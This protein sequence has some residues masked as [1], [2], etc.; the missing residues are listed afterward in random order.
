MANIDRVRVSLT[1]FAGG[2]GVATHFGL[3]GP[4]LHGIVRALWVSLSADMPDDVTIKVES[5]GDTINDTNG[6]LVGNWSI[7]DTPSFTG[8]A[9]GSY[10][11]PAGVVLTWLTADILDRKRVRG[12]T[13]VVPL[14]GTDYETNGTLAPGA[15]A[16]LSSYAADYATN[17]A[18]NAVVW[19]RPIVARAATPTS[20]A[21]AA[22][23]GGHAVIT[24]SRVRDKVA[25]L[26][27]RRD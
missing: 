26:R 2:P 12:R 24:S 7:A 25:V 13:F 16:S 23:V 18:G 4:A 9:S 27:S 1:G 8:L 10:A 14:A 21:R 11:A 17:S 19:H 22:R 5:A 3:N 20:P 6:A 15:I